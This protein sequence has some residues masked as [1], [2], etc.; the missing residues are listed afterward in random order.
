MMYQEAQAE[1]TQLYDHIH[2]RY[3]RGNDVAEFSERQQ[4]SG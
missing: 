2:Q 1:I 3:M 4:A